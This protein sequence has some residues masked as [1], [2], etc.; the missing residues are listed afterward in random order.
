MGEAV[1]AKR[2]VTIEL[3]LGEDSPVQEGIPGPGAGRIYGLL[4]RWKVDTQRLKDELRE[5]H[6]D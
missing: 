6:G 3:E 2:K 4:K 5:A 1:A